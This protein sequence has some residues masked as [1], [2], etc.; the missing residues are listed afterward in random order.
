[1]PTE[2]QSAQARLNGA[3]SKGPKTPEGKA[4]SSMNSL[5][6]GR[7]ANHATVLSNE[8]PAAF[9]DLALAYVQRIGPL[10][11]V[12]ARLARELASIDWRLAR[13]R[14]METRMIDHEMDIQAPALEASCQRVDELTRLIKA[15]D[16]LLKTSRLPTFL[17]SRES[18]LL[19]ARQNALS[20]IR[21]FRQAH[22]PSEPCSQITEP[23]PLNPESDPRS[24][25]GTNP[26]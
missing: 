3:N 17:A 2:K 12:E 22:P 23:K 16:A 26:A 24:E 21:Q 6:H 9:E 8:D 1:M 25:P 11:S 18:A 7:Y 14:A 20:A 10:D 19:Y 5:R 13:Y 4:R 15:G